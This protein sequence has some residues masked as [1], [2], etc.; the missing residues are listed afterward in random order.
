MYVPFQKVTI[1]L[2][3][4]LADSSRDPQGHY[5]FLFGIPWTSI[6]P[7]LESA[8]I[9]TGVHKKTIALFPLQ[10]G[11]WAV[12]FLLKGNHELF[13]FFV[14]SSKGNHG[15]FPFLIGAMPHFIIVFYLQ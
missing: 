9:P 3:F 15:L 13:P 4:W 11:K 7:F 5:W 6:N 8:G 2:F 12:S 1:A 14:P 10:K